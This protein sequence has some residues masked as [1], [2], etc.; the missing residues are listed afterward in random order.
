MARPDRREWLRS[1]A[2]R[3]KIILVLLALPAA[4][5]LCSVRRTIRL[6][7]PRRP[8][9]RRSRA[10]IERVVTAVDRLYLRRPLRHYGPCLRRSVTLYGF[11]RRRGLPVRLALGA[12]PGAA[13]L[14]AHAWLTLEG[15]PIFEPNSVERYA[16]MV[17]WGGAA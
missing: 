10:E 11:L 12:Y 4:L 6:L 16:L 7:T 2:L 9:T 15:A 13:G 5:R 1:A 17:E 14:V 3:L 8:R